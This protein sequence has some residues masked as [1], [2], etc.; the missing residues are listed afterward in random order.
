MNTTDIRYK[1][2]RFSVR[3]GHWNMSG[4][5][6][7]WMNKEVTVFIDSD[8]SI[9]IKEDPTWVWEINDFEEI[10]EWDI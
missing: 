5:M 10:T 2:R 1:V 4:L 6:D 3:P 9:K 8:G 7:K